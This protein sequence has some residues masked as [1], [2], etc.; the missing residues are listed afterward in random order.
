LVGDIEKLRTH[1]KID[2]WFVFGGSWG[3]TLALAYA[4]KHVA[5]CRGLILRGIFLV[6]SRE[7]SWYYQDGCNRFFPDLWKAFVEQIPA[8]ERGDMVK[9]YYRRL[10]S[11]DARIRIPAAKAWSVWEGSTVTLLPSPAT[12]SSHN[13]DEFAEVFARIECHYF[14]NSGFLEVDDQ[15]L[16]DAKLLKNIPVAIVQGRYD[17]ACPVESAWDLY[18]ELD[19][20]E[21]HL[22]EGAGHSANEVGIAAALVEIC[23]RWGK[24]YG[25]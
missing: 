11:E 6:R 1:L 18:Q 21:W 4:E 22:I 2:Q 5:C 10:T 23:N 20:A 15:L 9:A 7:I 3:S 13:E 17:M 14:I 12:I 25:S 24:T 19:H 8:Q 16:R